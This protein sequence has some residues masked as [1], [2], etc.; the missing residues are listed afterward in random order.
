LGKKSAEA[1]LLSGHADNKKRINVL[2]R[3]KKCES[4]RYLTYHN[5]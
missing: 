4:K 3:T 1:I 5:Q 2:T